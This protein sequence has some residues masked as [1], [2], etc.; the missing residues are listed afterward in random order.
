MVKCRQG[1][2]L[3]VQW[4]RLCTSKSWGAG[5]FPHQG[6]K[7]PHAMQCGQK[8]KF[9]LKKKKENESMDMDLTVRRAAISAQLL[10]FTPAESSSERRSH[11]PA[12]KSCLLTS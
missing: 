10:S 9:Q 8:I 6:T 5:S 12:A 4:V 2:S 11:F 3:V 1:T 7:I